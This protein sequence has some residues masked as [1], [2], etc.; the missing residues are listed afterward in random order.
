MLDS[1]SKS[2]TKM[3]VKGT[4]EKFHFERSRKPNELSSNFP[5]NGKPRRKTLSNHLKNFVLFHH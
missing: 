5:E 4:E 2:I 3:Q 1:Q